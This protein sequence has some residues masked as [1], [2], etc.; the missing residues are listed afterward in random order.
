MY[1]CPY[2]YPTDKLVLQL[3]QELKRLQRRKHLMSGDSSQSSA[4]TSSGPGSPGS[5]KEQPLFTLKQV[6][7]VHVQRVSLV[8]SLT[9]CTH[10]LVYWQ[11][12]LQEN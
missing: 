10:T 7:S 9:P 6:S 12:V 11:E 2:F 8:Y 4:G 1:S 5:S 3:S